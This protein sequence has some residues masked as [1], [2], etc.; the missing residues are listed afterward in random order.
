MYF[1]P[2]NPRNPPNLTNSIWWS[3][4]NLNLMRYCEQSTSI[5]PDGERVGPHHSLA[6]LLYSVIMQVLS[7][8][9][10]IE[11]VNFQFSGGG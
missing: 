10:V 2:S 7:L 6:T 8:I 1:S 9:E 3:N 5:S 11:M 4:S